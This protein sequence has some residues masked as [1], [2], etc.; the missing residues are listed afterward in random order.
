MAPGDRE[1]EENKMIVPEN[2]EEMLSTLPKEKS[3]GSGGCFY[4][5][6]GFWY[7][8]VWLL[9]TIWAQCFKAR[10]TDFL[11]ASSPKSGTTWMKA[12]M[13][14]IVNRKH[15][16]S[17]SSSS[18]PLLIKNPHNCVPFLELR[19]QEHMIGSNPITYLD[20]LPAASPRLLSTHIPYSSLPKSV[21]A[22]RIVYIARNPKDVFVSFW[23]FSEQFASKNNQKLHKSPSISMEEAFELFCNGVSTNGPFWDHVL[24]YWKASTERPDE[25]L[26]VKYEDMKRDTMH[27]VKKLAEFMGHPFSSEEEREGVLQ[28]VIEL[29]S[30]ENLSNLEV[31]K[32]GTF[33][34]H[35]ASQTGQ[36]QLLVDNSAFFR[37]GEVGDSKN[38]LTPEMLERLD[39]ITQEKLGTFGLEL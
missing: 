9:G 13:I 37:R 20:S 27:H 4:K 12:L 6:Q 15:H 24:G 18:H 36:N 7:S 3:W 30:F 31:N 26:F 38:H 16:G 11:L 25:V 17:L 33:Q 28:E 14:A 29:C 8:S 22:G 35:V 19:D 39:K 21:L 32:S 34:V 1:V 23:K 2:F 10:D 5:Y